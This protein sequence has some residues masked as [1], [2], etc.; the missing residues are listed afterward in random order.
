MRSKRLGNE[1]RSL[2]KASKLSTLQVAEHLSCGQPKISKI[3]NGERGVRP[4]DLCTLLD[5]Y[6]V[7]D[8]RFRERIK[9]LARDVHKVDWWSA[10]GP[11]I[12]DTL[13]DYLTLEADSSLIREYESMLVPGILQSEGYMREMFSYSQSKEQAEML[14]ETRMARKRL[15]DDHLGFRLRAVIDEPALHRLSG[16]RH[17]AIEQ[18]TLLSEASL[19]PNVTIQVLPLKARLPLNQYPP[20]GLYTFRGTSSMNVV[21]LEH[22][23][24]GTLLEQESTVQD[25]SRAWEELTAA[26]LAPSASR[27]FIQGLIEEY[28]K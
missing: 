7:D 8:E 26:A 3:E 12:H 1:L 6:G 14:V 16:D 20:F 11:L 4:A 28:R 9:Q 25:Y 24:G 5:L 2:R 18:L 15:L 10:Q 17:V 21:W 19:R 23:N 27:K 13:R 22:L